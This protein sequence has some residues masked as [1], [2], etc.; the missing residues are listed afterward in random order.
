MG[1]FVYMRNFQPQVISSI[2]L[3]W[4]FCV[5]APSSFEYEWNIHYLALHNVQ[6]APFWIWIKHGVI[7]T[8]Y[9]DSLNLN[10][11]LF[12]LALENL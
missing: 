7:Y 11:D 10:L 12:T 8:D 9:I 5:R 1:A 2:S 4:A 3:F 6:I